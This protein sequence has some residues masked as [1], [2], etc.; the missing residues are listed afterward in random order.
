MDITMN[1][2]KPGVTDT[3]Y[4]HGGRF[5]ADDAMFAAMASIAIQK[6]KKTPI[7]KKGAGMPMSFPLF[8]IYAISSA[9]GL[10]PRMWKCRWNTVCPASAPQLLTTR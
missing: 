10:P 5:H 4:I 6:Y 2:F 9:S 3:V 7:V 1:R 8:F